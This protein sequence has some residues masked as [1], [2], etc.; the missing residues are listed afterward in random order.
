MAL[1][2]NVGV[3]RRR[4]DAIFVKRKHTLMSLESYIIGTQRRESNND[5]DVV[6]FS[7]SYF[8]VPILILSFFFLILNPF[9][10]ILCNISVFE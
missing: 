3:F 7:D 6:D 8:A 4:A 1:R 2:A 10:L 5:G 9:V